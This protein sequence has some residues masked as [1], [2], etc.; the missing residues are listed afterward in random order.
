M[1]IPS[2]IWDIG[3]SLMH[4]MHTYM[5]SDK[6]DLNYVF[7][8]TEQMADNNSFRAQHVREVEDNLMTVSLKHATCMEIPSEIWRIGRSVMHIYVNG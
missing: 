3:R 1:D 5:Q 7:S 2:E 4:I 6:R 8:S